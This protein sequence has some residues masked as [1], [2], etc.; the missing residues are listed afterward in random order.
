MVQTF[1]QPPPPFYRSKQP[2]QEEKLSE[3]KAIYQVSGLDSPGGGRSLSVWEQM[4]ETL[5]QTIEMICQ[6]LILIN[7][8]N[9]ILCGWIGG[10]ADFHF[11][12][13]FRDCVEDNPISVSVNIS[14]SVRL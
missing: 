9:H 8:I 2:G 10:S 6:N 1:L 12:L 13:I 5:T 3:G 4:G 14:V 7:L 11:D